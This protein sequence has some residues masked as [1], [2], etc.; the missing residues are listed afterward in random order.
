MNTEATA[1]PSGR[2]SAVLFDL[3]GTLVLTH[4]DFVAMRAAVQ[5]VIAAA[6]VPAEVVKGLDILTMATRAVEFVRARDGEA[7]SQEL[8]ARA[9]DAMVEAEMLGLEGAGAAPFAA[10]VLETLS[11]K[12]VGV[13]IV[14]R[15]CRR[16]TEA[17]LARTGLACPVILTRDDVV[18]Y[19][20]DPAHLLAALECLGATPEVAVMVGDHLMDIQAG[21]AAGMRT[22]GVLTPGRPDDYFAS[23]NPD[24]VVK[25]LRSLLSFVL[26][27]L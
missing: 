13:A 10:E 6:G 19:K 18:R 7:A 26:G 11:A 12:G 5:E 20:P 25:D 14:T 27:G 23:E 24:L 8:I 1:R 3:D 2:V 15:N 9:E 4:I 21:R 16:A 22:I 17:V